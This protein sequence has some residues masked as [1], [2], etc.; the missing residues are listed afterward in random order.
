MQQRIEQGLVAGATPRELR[1]ALGNLSSDNASLRESVAQ[2]DG[3]LE[4]LRAVIETLEARPR[5]APQSQMSRR[6]VSEERRAAEERAAAHSESLRKHCARLAI[7]LAEVTQLAEQQVRTKAEEAA[8]VQQEAGVRVQTLANASAALRQSLAAA[9]EEVGRLRKQNE[10]LTKARQG[11]AAERGG[12]RGRDSSPRS[13]S[14]APQSGAFGGTS[15]TRAAEERSNG[16]FD[17]EKDTIDRQL[18]AARKTIELKVAAE[19]EQRVERQRAERER[20]ASREKIAA[21]REA[22]AAA[23]GADWPCRGRGAGSTDRAGTDGRAAAAEERRGRR[24]Q[25]GEP[26]PRIADC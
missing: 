11:G 13:R 22:V 8:G 25:R 12:E 21:M 16:K 2:R 15:A 17:G 10:T 14:P 1:E 19:T 6:S 23:G 24:A 7:Q 20:D 4:Q 9:N 3:V 26:R 18:E 5:E